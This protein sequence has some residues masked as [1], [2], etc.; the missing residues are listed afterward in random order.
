MNT[1][2]NRGDLTLRLEDLEP[3]GIVPMRMSNGNLVEVELDKILEISQGITPLAI[4][5]DQGA[6]VRCGGRRFCEAHPGVIDLHDVPHK[7]ARLYER[8]LKDDVVWVHF[9]KQCSEIKKQLQL[10]QYAHLA[11]PN[12][13]S[14]AWYHNIDVLVAWGLAKLSQCDEC[15]PLKWLQKYAAPLAEWEQLVETG[16]ITRELIRKEGLSRYSYSVLSERLFDVALCPRAEQLACDLVDFL[17]QEGSKVPDHQRVVASSEIIESL[18][19]VH[20]NITPRG[21]KPMGRLILSMASRVGEPPSEE[22]ITQAFQRIDE[23]T[24][25]EWLKTA[26]KGNT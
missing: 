13:R 10:T 14:K 5:K 4:V 18:F 26:F 8:E 7:I 3:L 23:R 21:P 1:L 9:T 20:K 11:P 2:I 25:D 6:D 19:G 12:Q 22:L 16:R 24:L 15:E 17:E